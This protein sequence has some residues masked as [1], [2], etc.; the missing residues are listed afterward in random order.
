MTGPVQIALGVMYK[1]QR[2]DDIQK[3]AI[4]L[5]KGW[6]RLYG[7]IAPIEKITTPAEIVEQQD[8]DDVLTIELRYGADENPTIKIMSDT[9][10]HVKDLYNDVCHLAGRK[11]AESLVSIY[12]AS[13]SSY[14][15]DFKGSGEIIK[16]IKDLL[17]AVWEQIRYWKGKKI[18]HNNTTLISS[19]EVLD[20][21]QAMRKK[22]VISAED[23]IKLRTKIVNTSVAI[24][25][26]GAMPREVTDEE[27]ISN[28][29]LLQDIQQKR[30]PKPSTE[31]SQKGKKKKKVKKVKSKVR[32]TKTSPEKETEKIEE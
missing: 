15:F 9:L 26:T 1:D 19:L 22:D 31:K 32:N 8:F 28:Q 11:E 6:K 14:R 17:I 23:A 18:R 25:E 21:I 4:D 10:I 12:V 20:K 3:I 16:E 5:T 2:L 27:V 29:K 30:L 13:G 24:Y 7:C